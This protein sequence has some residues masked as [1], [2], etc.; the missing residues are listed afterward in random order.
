MA[1]YFLHLRDGT[2]Q[3]L[4]PEGFEFATI[5]AVRKAVLVSARDLMTGDIRE[6]VIDLR[7][8]IDVETEAGDIVYTLPFKHAV[9]II[10]DPA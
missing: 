10:P 7:F 1:R 6:G 3:I 8:R 9:N 5:E 2:E 4:D